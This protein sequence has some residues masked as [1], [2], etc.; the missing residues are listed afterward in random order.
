[1]SDTKRTTQ[2][3][4][5]L[6]DATVDELTNLVKNGEVEVV[7]DKESGEKVAVKKSLSPAM[8]ANVLRLLKDNNI[9][10]SPAHKGLRK[11]ADA[12]PFRMPD[13]DV[14]LSSGTYQ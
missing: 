14:D 9:T 3:L 2:H 8:M 12:T 5:D 7:T 4:A 11:L 6:F 13:D 1:M 10:A